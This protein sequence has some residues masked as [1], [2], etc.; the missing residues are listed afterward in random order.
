[1]TWQKLDAAALARPRLRRG[2]FLL[3]AV[4]IMLLPIYLTRADD[5]GPVIPN[6]AGFPDPS[7][8]LRTYSP[9]GG[10]D[11][12]G[13]FF[14][15]LGTNGRT[16]FTCHQAS[17]GMS[18]SA[19]HIQARFNSSQ[20]LDPVFRTND[21]SNCDHGIDVST[22]AARSAAYSLLR[23]RGLIHITLPLP[24]TRDF[25]IVSVQNP[26][27]CGGTAP[28]SMYRRP[29]P[30][31]NLNFLTAIM[32]DGRE[33]SVQMGTQIINGASYPG[34]LVFDLEHQALDA[35]T[36]TLRGSRRPRRSNRLSRLS[37]PV[38]IRHRR[39]A[40]AWATC[41]HRE[42]SAVRRLS[43]ISRSTSASTIPWARSA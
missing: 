8:V 2:M 31:T 9:N 30:A 6:N 15:N 37:K 38:S 12:R 40:P 28:V 41:P 33:S 10:M 1:M 24:A 39:R 26:Y 19:A 22:V 7:G 14:Q 16:C 25:E 3:T 11:L 4:T 5:D 34:S 36:G 20:G 32:W 42:R 35:T 23:T 21:G 43:A 18:V 17:D 13:A 29:L 27:G